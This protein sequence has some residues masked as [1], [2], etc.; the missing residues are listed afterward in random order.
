MCAA[1]LKA[2]PSGGDTDFSY[3]LVA[4]SVASVV[5]VRPGQGHTEESFSGAVIVPHAV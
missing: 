3:F 5:G 1:F 2:S 4:P